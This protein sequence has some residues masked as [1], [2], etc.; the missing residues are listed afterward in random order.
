MKPFGI[1][2]LHEQIETDRISNQSIVTAS[3]LFVIGPI[4]KRHESLP[5]SVVVNV[6]KHLSTPDTCA[7]AVKQLR[8]TTTFSWVGLTPSAHA[9]PH[10]SGI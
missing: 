4:E 8:F 9:R 5:F 3:N 2:R 10:I 1:L 7:F 6:S